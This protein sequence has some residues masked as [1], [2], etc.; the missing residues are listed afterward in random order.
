MCKNAASASEKTSQASD[1]HSRVTC[2]INPLHSKP[3]V[4]WPPRTIGRKTLSLST[5]DA[6]HPQTSQVHQGP[7]ITGLRRW[8]EGRWVKGTPLHWSLF[9]IPHLSSSHLLS[10]LSTGTGFFL[11]QH[12]PNCEAPHPDIS[13]ILYMIHGFHLWSPELDINYLLSPTCLR[14][15]IIYTHQNP[16]CIPHSTSSPGRW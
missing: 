15:P 6:K 11:E 3:V 12:A 14:H 2:R 10:P 5:A 9:P 4:A 8:D 7:Y 1:P 16:Y 13:N